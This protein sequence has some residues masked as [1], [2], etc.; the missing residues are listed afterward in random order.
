MTERHGS[1]TEP[2]Q[3]TNSIRIGRFCQLGE[4]MLSQAQGCHPLSQ[5]QGCHLRSQ[6]RWQQQQWWQQQQELWRQ[7]EPHPQP[8]RQRGLAAL[9]GHSS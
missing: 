2:D 6:A 7:Q 8:W 3:F 5:A 1:R 4:L 9:A